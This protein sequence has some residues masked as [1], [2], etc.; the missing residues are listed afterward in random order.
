MPETEKKWGSVLRENI[1]RFEVAAAIGQHATWN[2][3]GSAA[4]AEL[5]KQMCAII[6]EEIPRREAIEAERD[7]L[8]RWCS[9]GAVDFETLLN[10]LSSNTALVGLPFE[11]SFK[12]TAKDMRETSAF[13]KA[14]AE[15]RSDG[16]LYETDYRLHVNDLEGR[17]ATAEA[18]SAALRKALE[19]F[20]KAGELFPPLHPDS[21]DQSVYMPA[22][23]REYSISGNDLRRARAVL[24]E[25]THAE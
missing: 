25:Q 8:R 3:A 23:G 24:K 5:L 16:T 20:A 15:G 7:K 14:A 2:A 6:D 18:E 22:A 17:L 4:M 9:D 21:F 11:E 13:L 1:A 19:P 10:E 12:R